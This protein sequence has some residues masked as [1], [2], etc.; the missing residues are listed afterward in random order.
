MRIW[1]DKYQ[2][3]SKVRPSYG[4]LEWDRNTVL[5]FEGNFH[6]W[7]LRIEYFEIL[8]DDSGKRR[9]HAGEIQSIKGQNWT[10]HD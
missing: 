1:F 6:S 4:A 2:A 10:E 7:S 8:Y 5:N 9:C 3:M